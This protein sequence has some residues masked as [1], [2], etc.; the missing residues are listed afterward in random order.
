M[1]QALIHLILPTFFSSQEVQV[2]STLHTIQVIITLTLLPTLSLHT[3]TVKV[4]LLY[5]N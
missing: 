4:N 1:I 5:A 3:G 2:L